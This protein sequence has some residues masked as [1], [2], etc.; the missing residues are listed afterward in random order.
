MSYKVAVQSDDVSNGIVVHGLG[1]LHFESA[2]I[3]GFFRLCVD[4]ST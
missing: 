3:Q 4:V 1:C 2:E